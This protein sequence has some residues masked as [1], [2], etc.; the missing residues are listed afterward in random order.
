MVSISI[1]SRH[2]LNQ[3]ASQ[4]A[5]LGPRTVNAM[6]RGT[7][8]ATLHLE[9]V[10]E[11]YIVSKAGGMYW[12]MD[13]VVSPTPDGARATIRT[14]ASK[15]HRI[16]PTKKHGLLVFEGSEGLVFKRGGVDHPGSNPLDWTP[17]AESSQSLLESDFAGEVREVL[18]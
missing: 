8:K 13:S 14:P 2:N 10:I 9:N 3:G 4:I 1:G 12:D 6:R 7:T 15:P 16:E 5:E 11:A 17:G 18:G